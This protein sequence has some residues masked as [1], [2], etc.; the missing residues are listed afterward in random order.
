MM[1]CKLTGACCCCP[2]G[3]AEWMLR[4]GLG[5]F[6]LVHG[7]LLLK[8][9]LTGF[10]ESSAPTFENTLLPVAIA[11]GF[12]Y[13]LP[14]IE[15]ILG[16][17]LV[18]RVKRDEALLATGLFLIILMFGNTVRMQFDYVQGDMLYLLI[19]AI[20]LKLGCACKEEKK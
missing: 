4:S 16:A 19:T 20:T 1:K 13:L 8:G 5:L 6:I 18:A 11:R 10:V 14:F 15:V 3:K 12:L 7:I 2:Q 17:L 9:G